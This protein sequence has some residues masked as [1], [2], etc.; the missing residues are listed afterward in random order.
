[1]TSLE[2]ILERCRA[3]LGEKGF[4]LWGVAKASHFDASQCR[5]G[6]VSPNLGEMG[7]PKSIV[8]IGSG[9]RGLWNTLFDGEGLDSP[10]A[11]EKHPI[12]QWSRRWIEE[13]A[14]MFREGGVSVCT[15]YPFGK[16]PVD[17]LGLAEEAGLGIV[18]PVV[19]FLLHPEFG[20]WVSLRG[21]LVLSVSL[22]ATGPLED[23]EPCTGC[24]CP[25][26]QVCPVDTYVPHAMPNLTACAIH[27]DAGGCL[28]G[29]E[30]RRACPL[31]KEH[32]YGPEEE[33]FR[34]SFSLKTLRRWFG[35]GPWKFLPQEIRRRWLR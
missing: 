22:E 7:P 27:R 14:K 20:P 1:M 28:G 4:N 29:C 25:C 2:T 6:R 33:A 15:L 16:S 30:V 35:L 24:S 21:A 19:P 23:F 17:F 34:H 13:A 9:G 5:E 10:R 8:I 31:G 3:F 26:L 18:S 11:K 32:R 12:D